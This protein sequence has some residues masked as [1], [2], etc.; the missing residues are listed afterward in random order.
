MADG[1]AYFLRKSVPFLRGDQRKWPYCRMTL[2]DDNDAGSLSDMVERLERVECEDVTS[3]GSM[4]KP[5]DYNAIH[6]KHHI[7]DHVLFT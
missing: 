1:Q 2:G 4:A 6:A 7:Q 5:P 3:T